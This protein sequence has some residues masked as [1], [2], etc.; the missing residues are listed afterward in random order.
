MLII[1]LSENDYVAWEDQINRKKSL[2][3]LIILSFCAE[4]R[5]SSGDST[6]VS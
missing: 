5:I 3:L 6:L 1:D 2:P 4:L